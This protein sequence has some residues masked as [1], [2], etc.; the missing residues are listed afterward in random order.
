MADPGQLI[1]FACGKP[2]R[3]AWSSKD[4]LI[5]E[6][7]HPWYRCSRCGMMILGQ[8]PGVSSDSLREWAYSDDQ[9]DRFLSRLHTGIQ[10]H[11]LVPDIR[12][13]VQM[14]PRTKNCKLLEIGCGAGFIA[15]TVIKY[16]PDVVLLGVEP[17][18][19]AARCAVREGFNMI[20]RTIEDIDIRP[21][22]ID[23]VVVLHVLE[24]L[25]DPVSALTAIHALL[26]PEGMLIGGVPSADSLETLFFR[27]GSYLLASPYHKWIPTHASLQ[28]LLHRCGFHPIRMNDCSFRTSLVG[29]P[30]SA[31]PALEPARMR[32]RDEKGF[33]KYS[34]T[35]LFGLL[36]LAMAPFT[37]VSN[38]L[39]HGSAINFVAQMKTRGRQAELG[40]KD[41]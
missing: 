33:L 18:Q 23:A 11:L 20:G 17:R 39:K 10:R 5:P 8:S 24:H 13:I 28:A 16:R 1:C 41:V 25:P 38:L 9:E 6:K 22:S 35:V 31:V 29:F 15:R 19:S 40:E 3:Y 36:F 32:M 21:G 37:V 27:S 14:L 12:F 2:V 7:R 26:K 4:R 30:S 34:K